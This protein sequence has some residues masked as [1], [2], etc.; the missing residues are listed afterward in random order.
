MKKIM[1]SLMAIFA[2]ITL[3]ACSNFGT[4]SEIFASN[5][6]IY[7]FSAI[8]S[9]SLLVQGPT[10]EPVAYKL[11]DVDETL[12]EQEVEDITKYLNMMEQ[13]LG[14]NGGFDITNQTSDRIEYAYMIVFTS[15]DLLGETVSHTLYYNETIATDED[16]I[17]DLA[18]TTIEE[19]ESEEDDDEVDE[20][21]FENQET[22]LSGI[23]VMNGEEYVI[24]GKKEIEENESKI[25]ITSFIDNQNYVKVISKSEENERKYF[26]E[27]VEDGIVTTSSKI[28]IEEESGETKFELEYS[29]GD[30]FGKFEFKRETEDGKDIIKIQYEINDGISIEKGEVKIEVITDP[31]TGDTRYRYVIKTDDDVDVET[32]TDRDDDDEDDTEDDVE[33]TSF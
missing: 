1:V 30:L 24:T 11:A 15:V 8:T 3:A 20:D 22:R 28:K 23:L 25:E 29:Q 27:I 2:L 4:S 7:A 17:D 19:D 21:E 18:E 26:Y 12:I 33:D 10:S 31:L 13:F 14:D 16:N 6:D 5:Q 32:E 9:T